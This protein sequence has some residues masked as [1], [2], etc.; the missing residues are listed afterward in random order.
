MYSLAGPKGPYLVDDRNQCRE[1]DVASRVRVFFDS[2]IG[3][4][5]RIGTTR[6]ECRMFAMRRHAMLLMTIDRVL[7]VVN[8]ETLGRVDVRRRERGRHVANAAQGA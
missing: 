8:I 5:G 2:T 4:V 1:Y 3:S 6:L 7:P